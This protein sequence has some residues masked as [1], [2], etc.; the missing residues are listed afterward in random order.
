M[1]SGKAM[2]HSLD[3]DERRNGKMYLSTNQKPIDDKQ[4][5]QPVGG[6]VVIVFVENS[7]KQRILQSHV[8]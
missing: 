7:N 1:S 4:K 8:R 5:K 2:F 6:K 3:I